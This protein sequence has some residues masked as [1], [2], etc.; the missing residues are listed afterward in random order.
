MKGKG[1]LKWYSCVGGL[2]AEIAEY[3]LCTC[4]RFMSKRK[5][6]KKKYVFM[7]LKRYYEIVLLPS[8]D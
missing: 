6:K 8:T 3:L 4:V 5:F 7:E 1:M 2:T